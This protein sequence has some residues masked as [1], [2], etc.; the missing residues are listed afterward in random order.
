M[1]KLLIFILIFTFLPVININ[2][3][4]GI[5]FEASFE[6]GLTGWK[7]ATSISAEN[8][9]I[10]DSCAT[11][12]SKSVYIFDKGEG[13][14]SGITGSMI[15]I[16][17][18]EVY[19]AS[20][21][22]YVVDGTVKL[23][24]KYFDKNSQQLTNK[25]MG[26]KPG[27]WENITVS[28]EAPENAKY[29]AVV[30]CSINAFSGK[31]YFDNVK[32]Y[33]GEV[34]QREI[35]GSVPKGEEDLTNT[36]YTIPA[37][38]TYNNK[39][40]KLL[41]F[42]GFEDG[43][44]EW[45]YHNN[46]LKDWVSLS[47]EKAYEGKNS[48]FITDQSS[49]KA[50]GIKSPYIEIEEGKLYTS[51]LYMWGINNTSVKMFVKFFDSQGKNLSS[52]SFAGKRNEQWELISAEE[53]A[54][55]GA[56][57]CQIFIA[58][59]SASTGDAYVDSVSLYE[60][61]YRAEQT[62]DIYIPPVQAVPVDAKIIAPVNNKLVYS[63]YNAEGD[64]LSDFSYA[65]FYGGD[66][67]LPVTANLPVVETLSPSGKDDTNRLQEAI[68]KWER[69]DGGI[70]VIK[71]KAGTYNISSKGIKVKSGVLLSGEGQGPTGTVL[72]AYTPQQY[73]PVK[74][75][76]DEPSEA[77][78][79]ALIQD[80]YL[81]AGSRTV[82]LKEE[83]IKNFKPGDKIAIIHNSTEEWAKA[84]KMVGVINVYDN[85]TT[86]T[87]GSVNMI[88][89]RVITG[90]KGNTITLD[91][92]VF[93]PHIK[94]LVPSY[95]TKINDD[96]RVRNAGIENLRIVSYYN[97]SKTDEEH[98]TSA[99]SVTNAEN[100]FIRD[101]SSKYF[102]SSLISS[103][104]RAKKVTARNCS[105][106]EPVSQITGSRRYSFAS[107]TSAQQILYTGCYSYDGRHD[108]EASF[109][110]TGPISYVDNVVDSSNTGSE[111]H[112]TWSTGVLFDNIYHIGNGTKG[113][114]AMALRGR[115]GT[116]L[117]QG[118]TSATGV[119]WN[120]L[121]ST[122]MVHKPPLTY[123]NFSVGM[124]GQYRDTFAK[125]MKDKNI[126][127]NKSGYRTGES[128]EHTE[129]N[130]ATDEFT[131]FVG[132]AYKESPYTP[133]NPRSL[134]KAQL[135]ERYTGVISNAKPNAPVMVYPKPDSFT[136]KN[137]ITVSG[138][139]Q[140]GAEKVIV[141]IDNLPYEAKL[142]SATNEFSLDVSL[143]DG[144]HKIY[145]TQVID[146][147]EGNKNADRFITVKEEKGNPDYLQSI[148]PS[149][150]TSMLI[151]DIR[152]TYDSVINSVKVTV[153]G[154][155]LISDVRPFVTDGRTLVPM[156]AIF[157]KIGASVVWDDAVKTATAKMGETEIKITQNK[158]EAYVNG[159]IY[160]LDV[161]AT[162]LDGRF[163]VPAR[164]IAESFGC[165]VEW[166][167]SSKT[168]K[169]YK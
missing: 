17:P 6:E 7:Y 63:E 24:F 42:E 117:S 155:N 12:G 23:F 57:T 76:G 22:S 79:K 74:I 2:A 97:G 119:M 147:V 132:D 151:N 131:S 169:I 30:L 13:V 156:R 101:I 4:E 142:N 84:I 95:I 164:F 51:V 158:K 161:P 144:V 137:S 18:G 108:F 81:K 94:E 129:E 83:D 33:K 62:P 122:I 85:D 46:S 56:K 126:Q 64:K 99:I 152:P 100:I 110:V 116:K 87:P 109:S 55:K 68:D 112:G 60:G 40:A 153:N 58:G 10:T 1:K 20:A 70:N 92:A 103:G 88:A 59:V 72:Y 73:I 154:E 128:L 53:T 75:A 47:N 98:A 54:P 89:E 28:Y 45:G 31:A 78:D 3:E 9:K 139:Y 123:Q 160:M 163:V 130:F 80:E 35:S 143:E 167:D 93:V 127:S 14:S 67:E 106:L 91:F 159:N 107:S 38:K 120:C 8:T 5:I 136:E 71:L 104:K 145:I 39:D 148:Y 61:I 15:E 27:K 52:K 82:T 134:Y 69:K 19:T 36:S 50:S 44:E 65:G 146:G 138:L 96:N 49:E 115:T 157:E 165:T 32:I 86:W 113:Y 125:A 105:S 41:Y 11:D 26:S 140:L 90:I 16:T 114:M 34:S 21:D 66:Y 124:W 141:Y 102:Y 133:V 166:E 168:V 118:W 48:V 149:Y 25:S 43:Y 37:L 150:I 135:S 29:C 121:A 162:V 77:G 111:T